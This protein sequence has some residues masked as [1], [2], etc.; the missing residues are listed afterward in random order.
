[1]REEGVKADQGKYSKI[2]WMKGDAEDTGLETSS[3]DLVTMAS[4]F[5]WP[6]TKRALAEFNRIL[7]PRGIFSALWNPRITELSDIE[8]SVNQ[9]LIDKY[10]I[11]SRTSS[12][13]SGLADGM[14]NV[15]EEAGYFQSTVYCESMDRV[16]VDSN[17]YIGAWESVNDIRSQLGE[18]NFAKFI[19]DIR[20]ILQDISEFPVFYLTRCWIAFK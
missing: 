4:A 9:L 11:R 15:L 19:D 14:T 12:G 1:M 3:V 2:V 8:T 7:K 17:R 13:R 5:H 20:G 10:K 16:I 6:E 18:E